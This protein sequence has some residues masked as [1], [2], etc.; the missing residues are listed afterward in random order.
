MGGCG[1]FTRLRFA[2][3]REWLSR[4]KPVC[5]LIHRT[6]GSIGSGCSE[7]REG[8]RVVRC[9]VEGSVEGLDALFV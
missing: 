6:K 9:R 7:V 4:D 3:A 5:E 1:G 8:G 2:E